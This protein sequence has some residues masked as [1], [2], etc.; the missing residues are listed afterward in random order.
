MP[1][2][3]IW[4]GTVFFLE[5]SRQVTYI[6]VARWRT[7]Q[8]FSTFVIFTA[9]ETRNRLSCGKE[10]HP[11]L[12]GNGS[13]HYPKTI[14]SLLRNCTIPLLEESVCCHWRRGK[15]WRPVSVIAQSLEKSL[16]RPSTLVVATCTWPHDQRSGE[17]TIHRYDEYWDW[18]D[19]IVAVQLF[20]QKLWG[21]SNV[22]HKLN[23][24]QSIKEVQSNTTR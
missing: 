20:G 19:V 9:I 15:H 16:D 8:H 7:F 5:S 18:M 17:A 10:D 12:Q 11:R 2:T 6:C 23:F 4:V 21:R 13:G 14:H 24:Q 22:V 3:T 1:A